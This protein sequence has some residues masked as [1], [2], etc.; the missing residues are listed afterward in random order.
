MASISNLIK[1][2]EAVANGTRIVDNFPSPTF[3][4]ADSNLLEGSIYTYNSGCSTINFCW[5]APANGTAIIEVWGSSGSAAGINC[6]GIGVPGNPGAYAKKTVELVSGSYICGNVAR[7]PNPPNC[8]GSTRC[9]TS[10]SICN[11]GIECSCMCAQGGKVGP[12]ICEAGTGAALTC[13]QSARSLCVTDEGAGCGVVCNYSTAADLAIAYGGDTNIDGAFSCLR[14]NTCSGT[15]FASHCNFVALSGGI[16]SSKPTVIKSL[17]DSSCGSGSSYQGFFSALG[18]TGQWMTANNTLD[19]T[20]A[21]DALCVCYANISSMRYLQAGVP[22]PGAS[23]CSSVD[24]NGFS[25]G[26]GLVKIRFI[27]N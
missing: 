3:I 6:C 15:A 19:Y 13:F 25:G 21:D 27:N 1:T 16:V 23:A 4:T 24:D 26:P 2:R 12:A 22:A 14:L 10:I 9:A 18:Q 8:D 20:W 11:N 5:E 17:F 7:S